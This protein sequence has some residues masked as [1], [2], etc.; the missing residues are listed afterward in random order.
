MLDVT[1]H[2]KLQV[3][4]H[5]ETP[6]GSTLGEARGNLSLDFWKWE[7]ETEVPVKCGSEVQGGGHKIS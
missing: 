7:G 3:S 4:E 1:A 2:L 6:V 5:A